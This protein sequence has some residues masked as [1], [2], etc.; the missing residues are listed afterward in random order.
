MEATKTPIKKYII[1]PVTSYD[2]DEELWFTKVGTNGKDMPLLFI[3]AGK[4]KE[5]SQENANRLVR[6]LNRN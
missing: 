5:E 1:S 2:Q 4:T 3:S 6:L